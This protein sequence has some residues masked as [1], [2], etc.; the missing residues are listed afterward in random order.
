M[1]ISVRGGCSTH[2]LNEGVRKAEVD[3]GKRAG[4]TSDT[5]AKLKA[6]ECENREL[7]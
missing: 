6:L 7:R 5:S 2:S 4:V 3:A 1:S